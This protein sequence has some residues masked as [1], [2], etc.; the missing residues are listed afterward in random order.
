MLYTKC[1]EC[2]VKT[3][4]TNL[5]GK[6]NNTGKPYDIISIGIDQSTTRT[7][8]SLSGDGKLLKVKSFDFKD[9]KNDTEKRDK[10]YNYI[11]N[12]YNKIKN[13]AVNFVVVIERV[14]VQNRYMNF[15]FI[16]KISTLNAII[17]DYFQK[18]NIPVFSVYT[19]TWKATVVGTIERKEN[20]FGVPTEKWL[21]VK[22]CIEQ[23]FE[24][25]ILERIPLES[26][27]KAG[28]FVNSAGVRMKYNHDKADSAAISMFYFVCDKNKI[29]EKLNLENK[30]ETDLV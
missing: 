12:M 4:C 2:D 8:I 3:Q 21:T 20:L 24:D 11:D 19:N 26:R 9:C 27:I 16:M 1:L 5:F 30:V 18:E 10:F 17:C 7:G 15:D 23:G 13:K 28:T 14:R 25:E 29:K 6:K 22:W